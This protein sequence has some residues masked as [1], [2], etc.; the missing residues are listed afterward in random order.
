MNKNLI[1]YTF[2]MLI[3]LLIF[4]SNIVFAINDD[5]YVEDSIEDVHYWN[6]ASWNHNVDRSSIDIS[7]IS[8]DFNEGTINLHMELN[9]KIENDDLVTYQVYGYSSNA[10]YRLFYSNGGG[11]GV[12][13]ANDG[14]KITTDIITTTDNTIHCSLYLPYE[15]ISSTELFGYAYEYTKL[16]DVSAEYWVDFAPDNYFR[17][18]TLYID[19]DF[20]NTETFGW[21]YDHFN[22]IQDGI[23]LIPKGGVIHV[24]SGTYFEHI[25]ITDKSD[26]SL[27][28]E[29]K[30]TTIIDG[31]F[32]GDCVDFHLC[33]DFSIN[34]FTI[35]N[36]GKD[37]FYDVLLDLSQVDHCKISNCNFKN[38]ATYAIV[39]NSASNAIID[40]CS[41]QEECKRGI[42]LQKNNRNNQ[43]LNCSITSSMSICELIGN[44]YPAMG[45]CLGGYALNNTFIN[46]CIYENMIGVY[47]SSDTCLNNTI[48][49]NDINH[50]WIGIVFK[51]G[52]MIHD[53]NYI[54]NLINKI[55][56]PFL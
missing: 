30:K 8:C 38:S 12:G 23:N 34:E 17:S 5:T 35:Q 55:N 3:F 1:R 33:N 51:D 21:Q 4:N 46:N 43:I 22:K 47:I 24:N 9:G 15:S 18:D 27:I 45:I 44:F 49:K 31:E 2:S 16:Y 28:G 53:N 25:S 19:D 29:N 14:R 6:G 56:I 40:N 54:G 7:N 11:F 39:L 48:F 52:N 41:I 42:Y 10:K 13:I 50:N 32:T 26:F 20:N 37:S 36:S